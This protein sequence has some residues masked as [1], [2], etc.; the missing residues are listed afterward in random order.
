MTIHDTHPFAADPDRA[1]QLR[2]RLG[3][4][5]TLWTAG[6]SE[7]RAGLTVSSVMLAQGEPA[8]LLGLLD[9]DSDLVEVIRRTGRAVCHLLAWEHRDLAEAFAAQSPAPGGPFRTGRFDS[10]PHGPRLR[11]AR[12]WV[13]LERCEESE[14]G[15]SALMSG[16]VAAIELAADQAPLEHRRGRYLTA[17]QPRG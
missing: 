12:G 17:A 5:V 7:D 2:G 16:Q 13:A 8:V 9:P 11:D 4:A 10:S 1:R 6:T 14:V 15:W 3:G